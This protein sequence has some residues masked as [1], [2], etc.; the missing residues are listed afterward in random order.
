MGISP[1]SE[2]GI[3]GPSPFMVRDGH[4][5]DGRDAHLEM[6]PYLPTMGLRRPW[7]ISLPTDASALFIDGKVYQI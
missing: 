4:L 5:G 6:A 7:Y 3:S 2:M 1:I